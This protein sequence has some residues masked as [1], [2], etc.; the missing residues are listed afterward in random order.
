MLKIHNNDINKKN[1][2]KSMLTF[3]MKNKRFDLRDV[4]CFLSVRTFQPYHIHTKKN[5]NRS[6]IHLTKSKSLE[7]E[8]KL[9]SYIM[10]HIVY[11]ICTIYVLS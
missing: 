3:S 6:L 9:H 5:R 10:N 1:Q 7:L 11:K 4:V 2:Q 8:K